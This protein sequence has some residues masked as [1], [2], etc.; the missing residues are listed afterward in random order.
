M[1]G[2]W[3][4]GGWLAARCSF[5]IGGPFT[6]TSN[7]SQDVHTTSRPLVHEKSSIDGESGGRTSKFKSSTAKAVVWF[8][9]SE[10]YSGD[11]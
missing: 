8:S 7:N 1:P 6:R 2:G 9:P 10:K 3:L 5:T 4:P 11:V